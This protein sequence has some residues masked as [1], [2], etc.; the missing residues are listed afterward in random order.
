M[1]VLATKSSM[2]YCPK[3]KTK[4]EKGGQRFC[5]NDGGRLLPGA[6][7]SIPE[8]GEK[9]VFTNLLSRT[10]PISKSDEEISGSP[11]FVKIASKQPRFEP[12]AKSKVFRTEQRI[13]AAGSRAVAEKSGDK[14]SQPDR[15]KPLAKLIQSS[16]ISVSEARLGDR[17]VRPMGREAVSWQT[18]TALLGKTVKGRYR[19]A[20]KLHQDQSSIA[21]LAEDKVVAGKRVV[22]RVLMSES[23]QDIFRDKM[24]AD[25]RISLSHVNHPNI[26]R[27]FDSGTL[28]EGKPFIVSDFIEAKSVG[29]IL[30]A[31]GEFHPMRAARIVR[32]AS[33][34]LSE[35]HQTGI[36]H[37]NLKP[38]HILLIIS[39][40]GIEQVKV[41]DFAV[42]DG[43]P[44][45]DNLSYKSPEQLGGELP[46][47]ASDSYSLAVIA[48]QM[49][50]G[51]LPFDENSER[52]VL[53][54]QRSGLSVKASDLKPGL[55]EAIDGI[56][57]KALC[58]NPAERYSKVRDLGEALFEVLT[59]GLP[60]ETEP[61]TNVADVLKSDHS[62]EETSTAPLESVVDDE[63]ETIEAHIPSDIHIP[64]SESKEADREDATVADVTP[65]TAAKSELWKNRSSEPLRERGW[66]WT[67]ISLTGFLLLA[68][69]T[70]W[71]ILYFMNRGEPKIAVEQP[72]QENANEANLPNI[73]AENKNITGN[74][75]E[76]PP[77]AR[78]IT[79]MS[80]SMYFENSKEKLSS[81][82]A[83][84]YRGFSIYYPKNW[85]RIPSD[86][87]FLDIKK[88]H[89]SGFPEE[90]MLITRYSS[91]G[92][93]GADKAKFSALV[94]KSNKDL[95]KELN[96]YE[97][98]AEESITVN[99]WK[100]YEVKFRGRM[101]RQGSENLEI[102]GRRIWIPAARP[103]VKDGFV[104]T[105]LATS[106]SDSLETLEDVGQKG[107]LGKIL[108]TFEPDRDYDN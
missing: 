79:P 58:F 3:C 55:T 44:K 32:Q 19:I 48:F 1:S 63:K 103:G 18:P 53:K 34:A 106:L 49:L 70:V 66:L 6:P 74:A 28:P 94:D 61:I 77:P 29:E 2:L 60:K 93:F 7:E 13:T 20:E 42:S 107:D 101:N 24:F 38:E 88:A 15:D 26:V 83:K 43:K 30:G 21:Y 68:F 59:D 33:M 22:I 9:T 90:Q 100:G 81:S 82:L 50:T 67:M 57:A 62:I 52:E 98:A 16:E 14:R 91:G 46:T 75:I 45:L 31:S 56:F 65:K 36:L 17:E 73:K 85:E 8:S 69:G 47:F 39:E 4:Y 86:T 89:K 64:S 104:I 12:P 76:V 51:R 54:A 92:T 87:N 78:E 35:V 23:A 37:R 41:T 102:W 25:E 97:V 11:R 71:I 105:M 10:S 99:G 27:V 80:D 84:N 96:G 5:D 40:A 95:E 72:V 108:K